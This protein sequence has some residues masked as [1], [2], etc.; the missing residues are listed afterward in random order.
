MSVTNQT[1]DEPIN[2][3]ENFGQYP[4]S[5]M[6][7]NYT[8]HAYSYTI[9]LHFSHDIIYL[10]D[11]CEANAIF[12]LLPSNNKLHVKTPTETPQH[13]LGFNRSYFKIN[14]F[15]LM[16]TLNLTSFTNDKLE[17]VAHKTTEMSIHSINSMLVKLRAC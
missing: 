5:K 9:K 2:I 3:N 8:L 14:N 1:H 6:I 11:G 17:D 10:P 7:I 12:F 15:N 16:L 13:K 4:P